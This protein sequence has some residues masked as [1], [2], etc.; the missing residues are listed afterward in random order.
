MKKMN[1][2]YQVYVFLID[3]THTIDESGEMF[4]HSEYVVLCFVDVMY[5]KIFHDKTIS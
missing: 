4:V 1:F 2:V 5:L 3:N